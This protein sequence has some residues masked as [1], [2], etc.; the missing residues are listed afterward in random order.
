MRC[1]DVEVDASTIDLSLNGAL[2][3][4]RRVFP[5]GSAIKVSLFLGQ[6]SPVIGDGSVMRTV[7][8]NQMGIQL[9]GLPLQESSRLQD[10]LLQ[11]LHP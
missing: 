10:F 9:D 7:G 2:L 3:R 1:G 8:E 5:P 6:N 11:Q 4:A